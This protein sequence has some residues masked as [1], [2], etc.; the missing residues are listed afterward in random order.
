VLNKENHGHEQEPEV[1]SFM[2]DLLPGM[3][4]DRLLIGT[5]M[6][7]IHDAEEE[8]F[9]ANPVAG[10]IGM[11]ITTDQ[12][13]GENS[14]ESLKLQT[15]DVIYDKVHKKFANMNVVA[16][17]APISMKKLQQACSASNGVWRTTRKVTQSQA[18]MLHLIIHADDMDMQKR[19]Q[20]LREVGSLIS[21]LEN[22]FSIMLNSQKFPYSQSVSFAP[23][24]H[25]PTWDLAS[26]GPSKKLIDGLE[27]LLEKQKQN[28]SQR[29]RIQDT[30][31]ALIEAS[32]NVA[33]QLE[34]ELFHVL[35]QVL[36][37]EEVGVKTL[38]ATLDILDASQRQTIAQFLHHHLSGRSQEQIKRAS[39]LV[40]NTIQIFD[41]T[42]KAAEHEL[43]LKHLYEDRID[44]DELAMKAKQGFS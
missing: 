40:R 6:S 12:A 24:R 25:E 23:P 26:N 39:Q 16:R 18:L 35:I 1:L 33:T 10:R 43:K 2:M 44:M 17:N 22:D 34:W 36:Q 28:P 4:I 9:A 27:Q 38:I 31:V 8:P 19:V 37:G 20:K 32:K 21:D 3:S 5:D 7:K 42:L 14:H 41:A 11:C 30:N 29:L 13:D 15:F